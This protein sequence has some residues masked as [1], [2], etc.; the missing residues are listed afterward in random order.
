MQFDW[1]GEYFDVPFRH[2]GFTKINSLVALRAFVVLK[3]RD[4]GL[5][6]SLAQKIFRSAMGARSQYY[7]SR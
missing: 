4:A 5:A 7:R 2:H 6:K 3:E 1:R